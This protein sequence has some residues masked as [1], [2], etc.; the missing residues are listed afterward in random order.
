MDTNLDH[1]A[2][3]IMSELTNSYT[4]MAAVLLNVVLKELM[5]C[6]IRVTTVI[7]AMVH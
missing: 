1:T 7:R 5:R 4:G 3:L 6:W 2:E